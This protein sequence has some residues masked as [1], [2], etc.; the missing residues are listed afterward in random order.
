MFFSPKTVTGTSLLTALQMF[1][2]IF[3]VNIKTKELCAWKRSSGNLEFNGGIAPV[4]YIWAV[5]DLIFM[6][7]RCDE[8]G[9]PADS[10]SQ[11]P[12]MS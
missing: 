12:N 5:V 8:H 7:N 1:P 9:F 4:A 3:I 11:N 10:S 6:G 2:G